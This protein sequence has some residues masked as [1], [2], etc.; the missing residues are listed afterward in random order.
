MNG[1]VF[2]CHHEQTDRRQYA[3]TVAALITYCQKT[4]KNW[5]AVAPLFK[6]P[7]TNP[8][9]SWPAA[10]ADDATDDEKAYR[11]GVL[12]MM[13]KRQQ[14][15]TTSLAHVY[16]VAWGQCS[17]AMQHR[18]Q[19][20]AGYDDA[21]DS[22]DCAWL[23]KQIRAIVLQF[24]ETQ[25]PFLALANARTEFQNCKQGS[26][27][28]ADYLE[29]LK[30][31]AYA[32]EH[33]GGSLSDDFALVPDT[34]ERGKPR[35]ET[36]RRQIAR[37]A[38]LA[39]ALLKNAD[40]G[41]YAQLNADLANQYAMGHNNYPKTL[42]AAYAVLRNYVVPR[43]HG[44]TNT[45]PAPPST[46]RLTGAPAPPPVL[47]G[48]TFV[49]VPG[50]DG[51][52]HASI[53][54]HRCNRPGHYSPQ[55]PDANGATLAQLG[56]SLAASD[57]T[58]IDPSWILLDSQSTFSGFCNP[59]LVSNIRPSPDSMHAITN[60]GSQHTNLVADFPNL[61]RVWFNPASIANILSLAH[62]L[63]V[64]RVTFDSAVEHALIIHRLDGSL[65]KFSR[66]PS[67]LFVFQANVAPTTSLPVTPYSLLQT[68]VSRKARFT[69]R[70]LL[71]ADAAR[72]LYRKLGRPGE[73]SFLRI[74]QRNLLRNCPVTADDALR[75]TLIYGPD[76]PTLKGH[77]TK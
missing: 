67:S 1:H 63:Q 59:S 28:T 5:D 21:A 46:P 27:S 37:G 31:W 47:S 2:Q 68:V 4:L 66:H 74:L 52:T 18:L 53:T 11:K 16:G 33:Y 6:D 72:E 62:V 23:L 51:V 38:T 44:H 15:L 49:T 71:A 24:D 43:R 9:V 73:S 35:D 32:I 42:E 10:L 54:C 69:R 8:K 39:I 76:V 61:G 30:T 12:E 25:Y 65:M 20:L 45:N 3:K 22:Q 57:F 75:A 55:C 40:P 41:R 14:Q 17:E 26:Q 13:P 70:E 64:C 19:S 34:D 58:G 60:G 77:T 36:S 29:S 7:I 48:H 50:R 56:C